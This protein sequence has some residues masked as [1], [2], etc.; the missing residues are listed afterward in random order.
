MKHLILYFLSLA[1][2][3]SCQKN[4]VVEP[5]P[6][7]FEPGFQC[8][9]AGHIRISTVI[10]SGYVSLAETGTVVTS[11][12]SDTMPNDSASYE[13]AALGIYLRTGD[14]CLFSTGTI[15]SISFSS[16]VSEIQFFDL[17]L[18]GFN[19]HIKIENTQ[20]ITI[21]FSE[22]SGAERFE[23]FSNVNLTSAMLPVL[24]AGDILTTI[25][26]QNNALNT[27]SVDN[28]I[29]VAA[30]AHQMGVPIQAVHLEG[31]T[32]AAPSPSVSLDYLHLMRS[33]NE[34][35]FNHN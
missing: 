16:N 20:V 19:P 1:L 18:T 5:A 14:Y 26:F 3:V 9:D 31:G 22:V 32:N 21:D 17:Q 34:I 4:E 6:R 35:T 30:A 7:D 12:L 8:G 13:E 29:I 15:S 10:D 27:T 11:C 23:V 2:L 33:L 24:E 28:I 25:N